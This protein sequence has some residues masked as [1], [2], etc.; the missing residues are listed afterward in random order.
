MVDAAGLDQFPLL[1]ISSGALIAIAY[2][3]RHPQRITRLVL[4]GALS[5]G[6]M[7]RNPTPEQIE[8]AKLLVK[9]IE[10]AWDRENPSYRQLHTLQ[11][12]PGAAK[13][14]MEDW[15]ELQGQ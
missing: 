8:E 3:A 9:L 13:E 4:L 15:N 1:G 6:I 14:Q 12:M 5:R 7:K 11:F 10:V 2:A